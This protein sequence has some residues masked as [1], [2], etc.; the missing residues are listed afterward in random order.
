[1][2]VVNNAKTKTPRPNPKNP[3]IFI[4]KNPFKTPQMQ[5]K[6][7]HTLYLLYLLI[8]LTHF[9]YYPRWAK[10]GTEATLAWDV[11]GYYMYLPALFIYGDLKQCNFRDSILQKY[12]PT[13]DFQQA[14]RH[15]KSGNFVMK[16]S[17]G[18]A[19]QYAPFFFVAHAWATLSPKYEADGFSFPYQFMI[20]VGSLLVTFLGLFF[21]RKILLVYFKDGVVSLTLAALVL[22]TNYLNYTA[23]DGAMT[24]NGLFAVYT[25]LIWLSMKFYSNPSWGKALGVGLLA[26]LAALTRPTEILSAIIPL[27]WGLNVFDRSAVVQRFRFWKEHAGM[28][29]LAALATLLTGSLQLFYWK[30]ATGDWI[31]YSYQDQGFSWLHPHIAN[32]LFSYKSGWLMYSPMMLF[33]LLGFLILWKKDK[34][35]FGVTALFSVLFI[36]IAFAWDIWWYGGSLG[37]RTMVQA[38]PVL[39]FPLAAFF[40]WV[41][42]GGKLLKFAATVLFLL[43][44]YVNLWFTHQA[45]KGG[46]LKVGQM[47]RAYYWKTIGRLSKNT[48]YFKLLDTNELYEGEARDLHLVYENTSDTLELSAEKERSEPVFIPLSE[49]GDYDWVRASAIFQLGHKE[50]N[51]W[52]MTQFILRFKRADQVVKERKIRVQRFMHD[53][54]KKELYLDVKKPEEPFDGV[55]CLFWNGGSSKKVLI[56]GLRLQTFKE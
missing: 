15:E 21:L 22:G 39:A 26:G 31:V 4:P 52:K 33:S 32:G 8:L 3:P 41:L 24:H 20:S 49:E 13:P 56:Y 35:L 45:H 19:I 47:T 44:T 50:W 25:L 18:Q 17:L 9:L 55:E 30:Y 42:N 27:L 28:L 40:D 1:M 7:T 53:G 51:V 48:E 37:Q 10:G 34:K 38:Y 11:S 23:I 43:F 16:Y 12:R 36:Y 6:S 2:S 5:L 14:F 29:M 54:Q 46:M